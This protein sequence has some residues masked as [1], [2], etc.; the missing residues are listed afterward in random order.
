MQVDGK[1]EIAQRFFECLA[2]G[3]VLTNYVDDLKYTGLVEGEDYL[4]YKDDAEM[5]SK[6]EYLVNNPVESDKIA[7]SG[8][9]K[10][11]LFH[12]YENRLVS[13]INA[14]KEHDTKTS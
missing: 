7:K 6:M 9:L 4:S 14:I 1:G 10:S 5:I 12:S 2:I 11:I 8:R 13:I 3:P